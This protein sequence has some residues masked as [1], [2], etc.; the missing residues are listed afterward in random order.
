[1]RRQRALARASSISVCAA[2]SKGVSTVASY[3]PSLRAA[4][5]HAIIAPAIK[6][7]T[8]RQNCASAQ[9]SDRAV[10][11]VGRWRTIP[12]SIRFMK[13]R[14]FDVGAFQLPYDPDLNQ[15]ILLTF[16]KRYSAPMMERKPF[17]NRFLCEY[18]RCPCTAGVRS[19]NDEQVL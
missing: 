7:L 13:L 11:A 8:E 2:S 9:K 4:Q 12:S 17:I 19:A 18:S 1:M 16:A 14:L 10:E 3:K 6:R 15:R 5:M